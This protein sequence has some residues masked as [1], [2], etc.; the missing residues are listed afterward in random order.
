MCKTISLY[1]KQLLEIKCPQ[2]SCRYKITLLFYCFSFLHIDFVQVR[3]GV[4]LN[5]TSDNLLLEACELISNESMHLICSISDVSA[6]NSVYNVGIMLG[7]EQCTEDGLEFFCNAVSFLCNDY[8][9]SDGNSTSSLS[10]ECVQ[11]RDNQCATE[12]RIVENLFNLS[13]PDCSSFDEGANL[14]LSDAPILPCPN[15]F[16]V[17]CG[18]CLPLCSSPLPKDIRTTYAALTIVLFVITLI[19]GVIVL[20][21]SIRKRKT[22]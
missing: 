5:I 2:C 3:G 18:L 10:E 16:G 15:D 22:M 1:E 11:I 6:L 4:E 12:W 8:L 14:T 17:F 20:I 13:L 21:T 7:N 9:W 19:G